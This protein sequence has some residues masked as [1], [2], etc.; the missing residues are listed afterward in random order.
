MLGVFLLQYRLQ[1][2]ELQ[3][4]TVGTQENQHANALH[5]SIWAFVLALNMSMSESY[6]RGLDKGNVTALVEQNLKSVHFSGTLGD[7]KF[8]E[9]REVVTEV[10]ILHV[11][12]GKVMHAGYYNPLTDNV[13]VYLPLE[14]PNDDF[15]VITFALHIAF[16]IVTY[17]CAV[18]LLVFTTVI[19]VLFIYCWNK[20][21]IKATSPYLSLL[22]LVGCYILYIGLFI[23][24]CS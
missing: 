20:P 24:R 13:T 21:S 22:I 7:I 18:A 12:E 15:E 8:N 3:D 16:P 17:I 4:H 6:G 1:L 19:L 5:D 2:M 23:C 9:E 14:V 11:K 10:D